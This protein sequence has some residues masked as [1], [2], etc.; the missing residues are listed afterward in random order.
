MCVCVWGGVIKEEEEVQS[1]IFLTRI[2]THA[3]KQAYTP[4]PHAQERG[5]DDEGGV[6]KIFVQFEGADEAQKA[7]KALDGRWFGGKKVCVSATVYA[8]APVLLTCSKMWVALRI[9]GACICG[10]SH[11]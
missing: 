5:Y 3:L 1:F 11:E 6:V 2:R 9:S 4:K 8:R 10:D 7:Q